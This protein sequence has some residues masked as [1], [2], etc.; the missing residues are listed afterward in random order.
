[1]LHS[2]WLA[3]LLAF[4]PLSLALPT[5]HIKLARQNINAAAPPRLVAYIQTFH[6]TSG[7]PLSLLPLLDEKTGVSHVYL[8]SLHLNQNLGDI[9]LNDDSPD[10][11]LSLIHI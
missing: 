1:M 11:S 10:H 8:S 9:T 4:L 2:I 7:N 6:D 3:G 5:E